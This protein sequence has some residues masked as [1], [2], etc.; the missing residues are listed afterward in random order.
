M[1]PQG[2]A[3]AAPARADIPGLVI[4]R[5]AV[6]RPMTSDW[7]V[8]SGRPALDANGVVPLA[9]V[10]DRVNARLAQ[11]EAI[12]RKADPIERNYQ[13][14]QHYAELS[15]ELDDV[16]DGGRHVHPN[17]STFASHASATVGRTMRGVDM[18]AIR[19]TLQKAAQVADVAGSLIGGP[20]GHVLKG[21]KMPSA[22]AAYQKQ[23]YSSRYFAGE[24]NKKVYEEIAPEF[25]R[26][27]ETFRHDKVR[28]DNKFEQYA[29]HFT[30]EQSQLKEAFF[31]YYQARFEKDDKARAE[32]IWAGNCLIGYHEQTRLQ[33]QIQSAMPQAVRHFITTRM[34]LVLPEGNL[35]LAQDLP[36]RP[37]GHDYPI[38]L[39]AISYPRAFQILKQFD[40]TPNGLKGSGAKDW[41]NLDQR[42]NYIVDLFRQN[43]DNGSLFS[44]PVL[45]PQAPGQ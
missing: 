45:G 41:S 29:A 3:A 9:L 12:A 40:H 6:D 32:F 5:T 38:A 31:D 15:R 19:R 27:S 35:R 16:I 11:C 10:T 25:A 33:E 37:D 24:G 34:V 2:G 28:D 23:D 14:T 26:F 4:D 21:F 20:L 43:A 17:W 13:I 1:H 36:K 7:Q 44:D 18:P 8:P 22:M 30:P 42:M 39:E